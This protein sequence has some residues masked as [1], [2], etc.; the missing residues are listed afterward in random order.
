MLCEEPGVSE[1][2]LAEGPLG[3]L[4]LFSA[5]LPC[6][7]WLNDAPG[8]MSLQLCGCQVLAL[9]LVSSAQYLRACSALMS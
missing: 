3:T 6:S 5:K 8:C 2:G 4:R 1:P 9:G 7:A